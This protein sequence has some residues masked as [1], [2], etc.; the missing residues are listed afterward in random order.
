MDCFD[1]ARNDGPRQTISQPPITSRL[2]NMQD[3]E[4]SSGW[5]LMLFCCVKY[6]FKSW[7]NWWQS[8]PCGEHPLPLYHLVQ[9]VTQN[10]MTGDWFFWILVRLFNYD[11]RQERTKTPNMVLRSPFYKRHLHRISKPDYAVYCRTGKNFYACCNYYIELFA[12]IF[13]IITAIFRIFCR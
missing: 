3:P 11:L 10:S 1:K 2:V 12:H 6:L 4:T 7:G 9:S 5:Q 8:A 13:I